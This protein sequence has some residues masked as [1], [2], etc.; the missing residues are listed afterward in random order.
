MKQVIK[1][2]AVFILF[3]LFQSCNKD[4]LKPEPLSFYSPENVY[5]DK[6][7]FESGLVTVRRDLKNDF[8]GNYGQ[9]ETDINGTDLGNMDW[10][11]D[12][13]AVTPSSGTY[14]PILPMFSRIY[15]F[16]KNTNIIISR[17]D[18]IT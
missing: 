17:I 10:A 12:W 7:G 15:G 5:V 11:S 14:M 16:I 9:L 1:L 13:N 8:Y 6:A 4:F 3:L 2:T 18:D